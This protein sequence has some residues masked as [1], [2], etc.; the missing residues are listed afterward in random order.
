MIYLDTLGTRSLDILHCALA[1]VIGAAEFVTTDARQQL[2]A[3]AMGLRLVT[4]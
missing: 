2:R 3:S 1:K 4:I